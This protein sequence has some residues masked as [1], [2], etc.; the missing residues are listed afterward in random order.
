MALVNF[1]KI[2]VSANVS[3]REKDSDMMNIYTIYCS[4]HHCYP[5]LRVQ[6][7]CS[8][9]CYFS[10]VMVRSQS[11]IVL[12]KTG[13]YIVMCVKNLASIRRNLWRNSIQDEQNR[14]SYKEKVLLS[15]EM[16]FMSCST[17]LWDIISNMLVKNHQFVSANEQRHALCAVYYLNSL[18]YL[19]SFV[20]FYPFSKFL[21]IKLKYAFVCMHFSLK[22]IKKK[23][24]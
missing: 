15:K 22:M 2:D 19:H 20:K 13:K 23:P 10:L 4:R 18:K 1:I 5:V 8:Y 17:H 3:N 21:R 24:R 11:K 12:N 7:N 6:F 14:R 9:V 16:N